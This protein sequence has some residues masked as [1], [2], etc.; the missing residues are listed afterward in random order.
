MPF[1]KLENNRDDELWLV[2]LVLLFQLCNYMQALPAI[3]AFPPPTPSQLDGCCGL[4]AVPLWC[5]PGCRS[6][7]DGRIHRS[8]CFLQ[9]ENQT[10]YPITMSS[11]YLSL[12]SKPTPY[13]IFREGV[14]ETKNSVFGKYGSVSFVTHV[15]DQPFL[16]IGVK[17]ISCFN[18]A[19]EILCR[20]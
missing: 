15:F 17:V 13:Q 18:A 12:I 4:V 2:W 11:L 6:R 5:G 10:L 16:I 1:F 7:T 14:G 3:L 8:Q 20:M 19:S 9:L